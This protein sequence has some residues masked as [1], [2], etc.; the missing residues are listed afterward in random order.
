[1]KGKMITISKNGKV[2]V[3]DSVQMRDFEI[4]EL[5]GVMIPTIRSNIRAILKTNIVIADCT[6][7][8]MLVGCNVLPDYHGLDMVVALA[9]RIQSPQAEVFCGW[10]LAKAA[11]RE[12]GMINQWVFIS[13]D[14]SINRLIN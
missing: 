6:N 2:S 11:K 13:V 5:L 10:V 3:P 8:A 9:F 7:G 1:M 12:S 14:K 4:A